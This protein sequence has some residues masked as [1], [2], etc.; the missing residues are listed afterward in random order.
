MVGIHTHRSAEPAHF[1]SEV[2]LNGLVGSGGAA[3]LVALLGT[4]DGDAG[5][6]ERQQ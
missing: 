4:A 5:N 1:H 3:V 2:R 6:S